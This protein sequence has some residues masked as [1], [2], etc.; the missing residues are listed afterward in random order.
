MLIVLPE[1]VYHFTAPSKVK[2]PYI[3]WAEDSQGN[4]QHADNV[5]GSQAVQG[6]IDYFTFE[7]YDPNFDK[8]QRSLTIHHIPF[9]LNSVQFEEDTGLIHYEWTWEVA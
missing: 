2:A 7:E 9:R 8:I 4:A 5:M 1:A 6:T 3:V